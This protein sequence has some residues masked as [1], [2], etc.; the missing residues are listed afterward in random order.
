MKQQIA[1]AYIAF[2]AGLGVLLLVT[3]SINAPTSAIDPVMFLLILVLA[4]VA[5][6]NPVVLFRSSAIS[7]AFAVKI[8]GYVLFGTP[9]ALWATIVVVAVNAYTP[10]PKP[11]RKV[12][13][14]FGQLTLATYLASSTYQL[15]GGMVP[16]GAFVPTMLAVA[17]SAAVYFAVNSALTAAVIALTSEARFLDVWAQNFSWMPVNYLATAVNGAALAL[18]YQS[19]GIIGVIVFVLPLTIA[20]Y[21]FRLYMMKSTQLRER[22]R[23]LATMNESLQRTT[24]R[25]EASHVSVIAA[26][27]GSLAA[28]DRYT[29][30]HSAATMQHGLAVAKSLGLGP[31]EMAAVNLGALF[32]DIGKIGIPEHILRKPSALTEEEWAEMKTHPIIGANLIGEVPNLERIRPIVLA[33]HEHYDGSGYPNGLKGDQIPLAA[34]IISVADTYEAMTSTRP[35][36]SALSHDDAVAEL[37]RVS[38]TQLNP[39][40]VEAFIRQLDAP[41]PGVAHAHDGVEHVHVRDRAVEAARLTMN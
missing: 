22:N 26:L 31:D 20:W 17:V 27:L 5:Q 40:V 10:K 24:E 9:V 11:A 36:R 28:K 12:L 3:S 23:E 14:N 16:P 4:G 32:H 29:Q 38:G 37:R 34:Q 1:N 39:V 25:L 21:S 19:L 7:V 15:V 13:F 2:L 30:G 8:A 6:R 41:G 33:H 18:A 35:Y